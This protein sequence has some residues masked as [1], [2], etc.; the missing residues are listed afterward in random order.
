M[1]S[2]TKHGRESRP[3]T[4]FESGATVRT[5]STRMLGRKIKTGTHQATLLQGPGRVMSPLSN[6]ATTGC[7]TPSRR[8]AVSGG[9]SGIVAGGVLTSALGPMGVGIGV[10]VCVSFGL[11]FQ[12]IRP[13]DYERPGPRFA[14]QRNDAPWSPGQSRRRA[15][16]RR[17]RR[18]RSGT[19]G[20][21]RSL[22]AD[23]EVGPLSPLEAV[24]LP[25][26]SP[27]LKC[28]RPHRNIASTT[29]TIAS[30]RSV[31]L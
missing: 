13:T 5:I 22:S 16:A 27:S 8:R 19:E 10:L 6:A 18:S 17:A 14:A 15:G 7:R 4:L 1:A 9:V 30:P 31:R 11:L 28:R 24:G 23:P 29:S 12:P 21:I 26:A 2:V 3:G 20:Y 25:A